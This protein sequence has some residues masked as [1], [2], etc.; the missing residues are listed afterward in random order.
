MEEELLVGGYLPQF[1][2]DFLTRYETLSDR[3]R[4]FS[5]LYAE[6]Y[7]QAIEETQG[8]LKDYFQFERE[9]RLVLTALRAKENGR[10][11]SRE[12]QFE[13]LADPLV[14]L[15]L[16]QKDAEARLPQEY[17][18]LKTAFLENRSQPRELQKAILEFRF[19]R[20]EEMEGR[21]SM[22]FG[23]EQVLGYLA[24]LGIVEEWESFDKNLGRA[25]LEQITRSV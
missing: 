14:V 6:F 22:P 17:E 13:D 15:L 18:E 24:R 8:F 23:M 1:I 7:R 25:A 11:L 10:D 5:Y 9:V 19:S 3:L 4:Y 20:I 12:F 16:A 21:A 2:L